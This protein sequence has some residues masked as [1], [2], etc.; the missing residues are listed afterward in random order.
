[1]EPTDTKSVA[2]YLTKKSVFL[3]LAVLGPLA[4]PLVWLSPKFSKSQKIVLILTTLVLTALFFK[5]STM[6]VGLLNQ[7]MEEMKALGY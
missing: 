3:G 4:L 7:R 5:F 6:V 2:W 1:M